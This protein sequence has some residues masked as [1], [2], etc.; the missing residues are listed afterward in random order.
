MRARPDSPPLPATAEV[1]EEQLSRGLES[2]SASQARE[3]TS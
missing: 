3:R 1:D 2:A